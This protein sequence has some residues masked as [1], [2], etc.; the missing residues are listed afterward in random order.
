MFMVM[1]IHSHLPFL[2]HKS[3]YPCKKKS[4]F[5]TPPV[6]TTWRVKSSLLVLLPIL[7]FDVEKRC[8]PFKSNSIALSTMATGIHPEYLLIFY[9]QDSTP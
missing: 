2:W 6:Q 4:S 3:L 8:I 9:T 1:A 7:S 5:L